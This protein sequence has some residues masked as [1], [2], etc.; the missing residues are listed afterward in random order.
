MR[1]LGSPLRRWWLVLGL[2]LLAVAPA[3][4]VR[5]A[6]DKREVEARADFAA[7]RYQHAIDLFAQLYGET[8]NPI[9]LRN[10]GRCQQNLN[11]PQA[12]INSYRDYLRKAKGMKPDERQ[13]IEGYIKEMEAMLAAQPATPAPA[14]A[15]PVATQPPPT[16]PPPPA[17]AAPAAPPPAP[18]APAPTAAPAPTVTVAPT[19]T[20]AAAAPAPSAAP[21]PGSPAPAAVVSTPF[22]PPTRLEHPWR[23]PGIVAVAVGGALIG[24]G[25]AFG[26]S[27]KND[28]NA[29]SAA[30]DPSTA[31]AGQRNSR[32]GTAADVVGVAA[33]VTGIILIAHQANVPAP[34]A[35]SLRAGAFADSRSGVFLLGGTF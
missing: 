26:I 16:A 10:I 11:Q 28:A 30:Y 9:Y 25:I 27:A 7:G 6:A 13:E 20:T 21:G 32:I 24:T 2:A 23:V 19:P 35:F 33:V 31:D 1:G 5:A 29:V 8:L 18:S 14:P 4:V 22:P 17:A 3:T 12:A 15:P 34:P